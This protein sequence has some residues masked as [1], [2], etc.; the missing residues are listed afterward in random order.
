MIANPLISLVCGTYNRIE[1]LKRCINSVRDTLPPTFKLEIIVADNASS[2]G[3]WKWLESQSDIIKL[4]M[5]APVGAIKAFTE[6]SYLAT[7]DYLLYATD[8]IY[9]P[10][11]S[12]TRALSHLEQNPKC[13]AVTFMHN[14]GHE[15]YQAD[16]APVVIEGKQ[17]MKPYTQISLIRRG[18]GNEIGWWGGRHP[19]MSQGFTY[20]GD[21]FLSSGIWERGYTVDTVEGAIEH[22]DVIEDAP[23]AMNK[24]KHKRDAELF[25]S[26]YPKGAIVPN[27]EPRYLHKE[28]MRI[29]FLMHYSPLHPSHR[30]EKRGIREGFQEYG[31][32][33]DY[34]YAGEHEKGVDINS[35]FRRICE[36]FKPH[37]IFTQ[38]HNCS[39]GINEETSQILRSAAPRAVMINWNG[40][41]WTKNIKHPRTQNLLKPYDILTFTSSQLCELATSKTGV[42]SFYAANYFEPASELAN[43]PAFDVLFTGTAYTPERLALMKLIKSLPCKTGIY[44]NGTDEIQMEGNTHYEWAT[45]CGLYK[46]AKII[47][48]DQQFQDAHGYVSNRLWESMSVGGGLCLQQHAPKLDEM[49]GVRAGVH[50]VEW[51]TMD[52]LPALVA[53]YL[54]HEDEARKI[55]EAA[56]AYALKN[57]SCKKR[58]QEYFEGI[59]WLSKPDLRHAVT[60][61]K[62]I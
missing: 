17:V 36:A 45:T 62:M 58:V 3:T 1:T 51:Q 39:N 20:A 22:E 19:V 8:D 16:Y 25:F 43:M 11:H 35:E 46:R 7:G 32:V 42:P 5:G 27:T 29:L 23:R 61:S 54:E 57:A 33:Y 10:P 13:G 21:N 30:L 50:Y 59:I 47:I 53:Y 52:E 2:D 41:V 44:G 15:G 28:R 55:V 60:L 31:I 56:Q 9:F 49:T 18:L 40:D 37:L 12:I 14:K 38:F 4:Q 24:E 6:A 34:D 26:L 48:S